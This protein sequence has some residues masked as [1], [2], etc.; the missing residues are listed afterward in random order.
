MKSNEKQKRERQINVPVF[1]LCMFYVGVRMFF[2]AVPKWCE[3]RQSILLL[4]RRIA[5][6]PIN[7]KE[8]KSNRKEPCGCTA[9][10]VR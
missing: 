5:N 6:Y 3:W 4:M 9:P 8:K 1:I 7:G 2:S 10:Q